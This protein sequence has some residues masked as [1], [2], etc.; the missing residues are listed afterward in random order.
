MLHSRDMEID[1]AGAGENTAPL[2]DLD[3]Y[4]SDRS[5]PRWALALGAVFTVTIALCITALIILSVFFQTIVG[6]EGETAMVP[7]L[8]GVGVTFLVGMLVL[9]YAQIRALAGFRRLRERNSRK[10]RAY[11]TV[12][13]FLVLTF[14]HP[15]SGLA[16]PIGVGVGWAGL[17]LL[18]R[19]TERGKAWE[20]PW[21]FLPQEALSILS[22]RDNRGV[23]LASSQSDNHAMARVFQRTGA[24]LAALVA[25]ASG[26]YL[27]AQ[28]I[29][30][31]AALLALTLWSYWIVDGT[32]AYLVEQTSAR[33]THLPPSARVHYSP[34]P[35]GN[36]PPEGLFV[37]NLS[38]RK[39]DGELLLSDI[40]IHVEPGQVI[41]II[42]DSGAGK[43]L[44]LQSL[45]DPFALSDMDVAGAAYSN[46]MD[47]WKRTSG[48]QRLPL[49]YVPDQPILLPASGA[50]NLSCYQGG[51]VLER[52][53]QFLEQMVFAH[54]LVDSICNCPDA[55]TL[56]S[57]QRQALALTRA[58][59]LSPQ[60]YLLDRPEEF[61]GAGQIS[62]L[63]NRLDME[64]RLGRCVMVVSDHRKLLDKCDQ[65]FILQA[66]RVVDFGP[67]EQVRERMDNGWSRFVSTRHLSSEDNLDSWL[68]S[69]FRRDGDDANRRKVCMIA[70]E[71]LA[72]S[73][74][75]ADPVAEQSVEFLFKH[76][77]GHCQLHMIDGSQ[78]ISTG[79]M[80]TA[81]DLLESQSVEARRNLLASVMRHCA[82]LD[83]ESHQNGRILKAKIDT[84][85]PRKVRAKGGAHAKQHP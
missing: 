38:V 40:S 6:I 10:I 50:D 12:P 51:A 39:P 11:M 59:I 55:R 23:H 52:G 78:P 43:S 27:V 13:L 16:L 83:A 69:Q 22:G 33:D 57:M 85:D 49:S 21:N 5:S 28:E 14:I 25:V 76:F 63:C 20:K 67:A 62:A 7:A 9:E 75:D 17:R 42:G 41:G 2:T 77:E 31:P 36:P 32:L 56:P 15:L 54:D 64:T 53:R 74:R 79:Q 8:L 44:L 73:C 3:I 68:R 70:S 45:A 80:K 4:M 65:L 84:Y 47:L 60:V 72:L 48:D 19:R 37:R 1:L 82:E 26:A 58:F 46:G 34:D 18:A 35:D 29:L 71:M 81:A 24:W 30:A 61:L 66:G